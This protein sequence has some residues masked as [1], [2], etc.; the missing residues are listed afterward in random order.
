LATPAPIPP[1]ANTP[2]AAAASLFLTAILNFLPSQTSPVDYSEHHPD[3]AH[4]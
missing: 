2:N 3:P 4:L 1:N